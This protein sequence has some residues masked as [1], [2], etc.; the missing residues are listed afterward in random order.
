MLYDEPF[1]T[2]LDGDASQEEIN[3]LF[4]RQD[5]IA[6]MLAGKE[7]PSVIL[8]MV[9]EHGLDPIAYSVNVSNAIDEIIGLDIPIEQAQI[10][11]RSRE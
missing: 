1:L 4:Q 2:W 7:S 6:R 8:D 9:S 11:L 3:N 5:A 10:I